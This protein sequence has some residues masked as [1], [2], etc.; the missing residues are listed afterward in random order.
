MLYFTTLKYK[1]LILAFRGE[2]LK[3]RCLIIK[4]KKAEIS[5]NLIRL[6]HSFSLCRSWSFCWEKNSYFKKRK[7]EGGYFESENVVCFSETERL[8]C[9]SKESD[10]PHRQFS[11]GLKK[12]NKN[13][14]YEDPSVL[15][16][17]SEQGNLNFLISNCVQPPLTKTE[18]KVFLPL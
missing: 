8:I 7:K 13:S 12:E 17:L 3:N 18:N 5:G 9:S 10:I 4:K 15:G 11:L 14:S 1:I 6:A 16:N 2:I